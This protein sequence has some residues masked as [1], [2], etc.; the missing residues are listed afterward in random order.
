VSS[1]PLSASGLC[2]V[3][4]AAILACWRFLARLRF[5]LAVVDAAL[6]AATTAR[7]QNQNTKQHKSGCVPVRKVAC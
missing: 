7:M 3:A 1:S 6:R 4:A 5:L 2:F